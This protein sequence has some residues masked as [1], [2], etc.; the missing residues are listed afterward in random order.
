MIHIAASIRRKNHDFIIK[1]INKFSS[2][3]S[4]LGNA[5]DPS[6][7]F[8]ML[9]IME[10]VVDSLVRIEESKEVAACKC[11]HVL[12]ELSIWWGSSLALKPLFLLAFVSC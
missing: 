8:M 10:V 11:N 6:V 2:K 3:C 7:Y 9:M 12:E 5:I 1:K 4:D